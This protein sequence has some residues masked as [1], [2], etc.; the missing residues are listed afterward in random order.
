MPQIGEDRGGF[1][2]LKA[3]AS[4]AA[5]GVCATEN[6]RCIEE[7]GAVGEGVAQERSVHFA[8][9]FDEKTGHRDPAEFGDQPTEIDASTGQRCGPDGGALAQG[10]DALWGCIRTGDHDGVCREGV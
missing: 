7:C 5:R 6:L 4:D 8:A 2:G 9:S 10:G 3:V 1:E